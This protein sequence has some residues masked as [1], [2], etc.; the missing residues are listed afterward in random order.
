MLFRILLVSGGIF[1]LIIAMFHKVY[2]DGE[3]L[4]IIKINVA[5]IILFILIGVSALYFMFSRNFYL[6][7]LGETAV[8][9]SVLFAQLEPSGAS[10]TKTISDLRPGAKVMYWASNPS[11]TTAQSPSIAYGNYENAG[12]SVVNKSGE[13]TLRIRPPCKYRVGFFGRT[14]NPH[15][16]YRVEV[17]PSIFS[18]VRTLLL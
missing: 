8:P 17:H 12:V 2:E 14:V 11:K 5:S 1:C 7:F 3:R 15:I 10:I 16:H 13:A 4:Y 9:N 6:P 18:E